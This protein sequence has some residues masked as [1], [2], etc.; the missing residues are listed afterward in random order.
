MLLMRLFALLEKV[1]KLEYREGS[2][3]AKDI[4]KIILC[5]FLVP[6]SHDLKCFYSLLWFVPLS[7]GHG[8]S[9]FSACGDNLLVHDYEK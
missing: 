6:I 4:H 7:S 8:N 1:T 2:N 5:T 3:K 9:G